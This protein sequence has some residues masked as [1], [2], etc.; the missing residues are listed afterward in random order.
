MTGSEYLCWY[1]VQDLPNEILGAALAAALKMPT[2]PDALARISEAVEE[3]TIR[4]M[5]REQSRLIV[6]SLRSEFGMPL[7]AAET[8][9]GIVC[10]LS[11]SY[12]RDIHRNKQ[13]RLHART[14]TEG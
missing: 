11:P 12:V 13:D 7:K 1:N 6:L 2:D 10:C 9:A 3:A 8:A 4:A 14:G 5:R